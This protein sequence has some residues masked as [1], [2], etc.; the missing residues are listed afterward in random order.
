ML[1]LEETILSMCR[2]SRTIIFR[3]NS[4]TQ[5]QML[6]FLSLRPPCLCPSEGHKHGVSIQSSINLCDT[7]LQITREWKTAETWFLARLFIYQSSIVSQSLDFFI[8][9]LRF[10]VLITG[11]VKTESTC[12][13]HIKHGSYRSSGRGGKGRV[14]GTKYGTLNPFIGGITYIITA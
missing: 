8:E 3:F 7:L 10:L 2:S 1:A 14:W 6:L 12:L 9:W 4:K 5:W 11:L 13:L